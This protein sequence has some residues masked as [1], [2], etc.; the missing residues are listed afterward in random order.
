MFVY[1]HDD[2]YVVVMSIIRGSVSSISRMTRA[3]YVFFEVYVDTNT[4]LGSKKRL[5]HYHESR[6]LAAVA[7]M[8]NACTSLLHILSNS[9]PSAWR[10]GSQY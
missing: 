5:D 10:V 8:S 1:K 6:Y 9:A 7:P 4:V 2:N 3:I